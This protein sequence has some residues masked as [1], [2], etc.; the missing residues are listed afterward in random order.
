M[1]EYLM[2]G[3]WLD[4]WER[5]F[6]ALV[7]YRIGHGATQAARI[8]NVGMSWPASWR[9]SEVMQRISF[10]DSSSTQQEHWHHFTRRKRK[11]SF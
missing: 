3:R 5:D 10:V 11:E 9:A 6:G 8:V 1:C 2:K 7:F 4:C